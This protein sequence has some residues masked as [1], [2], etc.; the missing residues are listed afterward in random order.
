MSRY[1]NTAPF[2]GH[3][4]IGMSV[5]PIPEGFHTVTPVLAVE[6]GV[7]A[8]DFYQRAFG[9]EVRLKLVMGGKL[10]H[11]ELKIGDSIVCVNDSF[12]EYGSVAPDAN[13]PVPV[14]LMIYT[15]DCDAVFAQAVSA[16]ATAVNEPSDQFHGDRAGSL[17]DPYG[18]RWMI[19]THIEDM[20]EEEMQR[21]TEEAMS[22]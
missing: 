22:S 16:G 18:H 7:E 13:E 15:E 10:M 5:K 6:G 21:R 19:V 9:A 11:S 20:T 1:Y 2:A 14:A 8:L 3:T 4:V 12:P 17:R